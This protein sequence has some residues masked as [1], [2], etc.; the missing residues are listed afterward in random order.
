MTKSSYEIELSTP[1]QEYALCWQTAGKHLSTKGDGAINWLKA[2]LTPP[3]LEHLPFRLGNQLFYIRLVD[4]DDYAQMPGNRT[5]LMS[6]VKG[7]KGHACLMPLK[8]EGDEWRVVG[9]DWGLISADTQHPINPLELIQ[10]R[11]LR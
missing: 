4:V 5:G 11:R 8:N 6:V 2:D 9:D 3:F 10:T 1:S 7:C